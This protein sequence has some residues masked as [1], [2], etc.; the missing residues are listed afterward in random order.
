VCALLS[1]APGCRDVSSQGLLRLS[2]PQALYSLDPD[3]AADAAS[4]AVL[5]NIYEGVVALDRDMRIVPALAVSWTVPDDRTWVFELRHG[6]KFHDGRNMTAED[7]RFSIERVGGPDKPGLAWD[8]ESVEAMDPYR[9]RVRTRHPDPFLLNRLSQFLVVPQGTDPDVT[10]V[11]TGP[12]RVLERAPSLELEAFADYWGGPSS[13]PRVSFQAIP[14]AGVAELLGRH[15]VDVYRQLPAPARGVLRARGDY[16]A[17]GRPGVAQTYLWINCAP[18]RAGRKNPFADP[19]VR[20]AVSG[21]LDRTD[22]ATRLGGGQLPGNQ[23]VPKGVFGFIPV[24]DP[25]PFDPEGSRALLREA[26]YPDG[27]DVKLSFGGAESQRTLAAEIRGML[28]AIGVR[29]VPEELSWVDLLE[30]R[31][32]QRLGL[33]ALSWTFDDGDAGTFLMAS[34]HT[35]RGPND[36][37]STNPGYSNATLDRLIEAGLEARDTEAA[38]KGYE[39]AVRLALQE[40]PLIP[41]YQNYDLYAASSRVAFEPRIDGKLVARDMR[42]LSGAPPP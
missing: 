25:I 37:R 9:L 11:G 14:D 27:F 2:Q 10:P 13:I 33:F 36:F 4:R 1:Q 8:L 24:L 42:L 12:Y 20:R 41:L 38:R 29:V 34:L 3:R 7:V 28:A 22:I 35:R 39:A 18:T 17:V 19:R 15:G 32:D 21:A 40:L 31:R 16:R 30:G 6:I 23:L 5:C 26:G